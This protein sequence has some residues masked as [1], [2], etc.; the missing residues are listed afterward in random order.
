[1]NRINSQTAISP[2][3]SSCLP[4]VVWT[5]VGF[6][7]VLRLF[8]NLSYF[9]ACSRYF[10]RVC[11]NLTNSR[12]TTPSSRSALLSWTR[13]SRR[14]ASLNLQRTYSAEFDRF[15][16]LTINNRSGCHLYQVLYEMFYYVPLLIIEFDGEELTVWVTS[17]QLRQLSPCAISS[18]MSRSFS[19]SC[20]LKGQ[21]TL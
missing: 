12:S 20:S 9:T 19:S 3:L 4:S 13:L 7:I 18:T 6:T 21:F 15:R 1:M 2:I 10:W 16:I 14:L 8:R 17:A 11:C 5:S